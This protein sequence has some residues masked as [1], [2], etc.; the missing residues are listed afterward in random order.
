MVFWEAIYRFG[1]SCLVQ[2]GKQLLMG[3]KKIF[4]IWEIT[5][6][7]AK[8]QQTTSTLVCSFLGQLIKGHVLGNTP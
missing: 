4:S 8:N 7:I 1:L 2:N 3:L 5:Q 6:Y